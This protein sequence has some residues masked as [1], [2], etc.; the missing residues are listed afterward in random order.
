MGIEDLLAQLPI[1]QIAAQLGI[2]TDEASEASRNALTALVG[3]LDA[4]AKDPGGASSLAAAL[5]KHAEAPDLT[6]IT[7]VDTDDGQK[8]VGHVFGDQV[9]GVI[10]QLGGLGKADGGL[11][12]KLLPMLAPL[13]MGW[14]GKSAG[15]GSGGTAAAARSGGGGG[16][17]DLLGGGG[18]GDLLGGGGGG[19]LGDLLGGLLGGGKDGKDGGG[20]DLGSVFGGLLGGGTKG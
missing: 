12:A 13:V 9:D 7:Q 14:L 19:G 8:I 5:A 17:G 18:L 15:K 2:D 4:N 11:F 20:I 16:L 1:D 10:S 6:D 3:G